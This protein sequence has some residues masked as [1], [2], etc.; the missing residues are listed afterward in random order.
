MKVTFIAAALA[1]AS[2]VSAITIKFANNCPHRAQSCSQPRLR[3]LANM[4]SVAV[5]AAI[6]QAPNGVPATTNA[7][8]VKLA[9]KGASMPTA[10]FSVPDTALVSS[11][12]T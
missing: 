12:Q 3:H 7:H 10:S 11:L 5:W 9:A 8:G 4:I 1:C 6:G 2:S